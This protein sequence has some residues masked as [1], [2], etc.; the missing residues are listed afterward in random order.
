MNVYTIDE[1][2]LDV[3]VH[4]L[5]Y[6]SEQIFRNTLYTSRHI[7]V[8]NRNGTE[9]VVDDKDEFHTVDI[10]EN[11]KVLHE[12]TMKQMQAVI[13][14]A[15]GPNEDENYKAKVYNIIE[16]A[17]D[18]RLSKLD[19]NV[20]TP[21][22]MYATRSRF[23]PNQIALNDRIGLARF[24][25]KEKLF[26]AH[27]LVADDALFSSTNRMSVSLGPVIW[28]FIR[29]VVL[30]YHPECKKIEL[31]MKIFDLEKLLRYVAA[32]FTVCVCGNNALA[33]L[34]AHSEIK[35]N[36]PVWVRNLCGTVDVNMSP[37]APW[38]LFNCIHEKVKFNPITTN[39]TKDFRNF[40]FG[41]K[42]SA[43][44]NT[45]SF[46][47]PASAGINDQA[48]FMLLRMHVPTLSSV[49]LERLL[50]E[51]IYGKTIEKN[52]C[53][54]WYRNRYF[55]TMAY[56]MEMAHV[57][58]DYKNIAI[59]NND[60][61]TEM[62]V[63]TFMSVFIKGTDLVD[64]DTSNILTINGQDYVQDTNDGD[65]YALSDYSIQYLY[66]GIGTDY[67]QDSLESIN[68]LI[69]DLQNQLGI[70]REW[71]VAF[72]LWWSSMNNHFNPILHIDH[73]ARMFDASQ[74]PDYVYQMSNRT[75][76]NLTMCH[77]TV[78]RDIMCSI[79]NSRT[80]VRY[81][82]NLTALWAYMH[83]S[84]ESG[85]E[86]YER[87]FILMRIWLFTSFG[88]DFYQVLDV[89]KNKTSPKQ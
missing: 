25:N 61:Q 40:T 64:N 74:D 39:D 31:G 26:V 17:M 42:I 27:N 67:A 28:E 8:E 46:F 19:E 68:C 48:G 9:I 11:A 71:S 85:A 73:I 76:A 21:E 53:A 56:L 45:R 34:Y 38:A 66:T 2:V 89:I 59:E 22:S 52:G 87:L 58:V 63:F 7:K 75:T 15:Y 18:I 30:H 50:N 69:D 29:L 32:A 60:E 33:F 80:F 10:Q 55:M 41:C 82:E 44:T 84:I 57:I 47:D 51:H 6:W 88:K 37:Y 35:S 49:I 36:L 4:I 3:S 79:L 24:K 83:G 70:D 14:A 86:F 62:D 13:D 20:Y 81:E 23:V 54:Q 78:H 16:D 72:L 77:P 65:R 12:G 1:P 43:L 5:A